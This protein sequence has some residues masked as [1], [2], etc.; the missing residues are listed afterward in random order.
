MKRFWLLFCLIIVAFLVQGQVTNIVDSIG[1]KQGVWREFRVVPFSS[2]TSKIV[3]T[4]PLD[5]STVLFVEDFDFD[6]EFLL[7]ESYG[8]YVD[9]LRSGIWLEYNPVGAYLISKVQYREGIPKGH[10]E[11]FWS[12]GNMK[13]KCFIGDST[14]VEVS[15]FYESGEIFDTRLVPKSEIIKVLYEE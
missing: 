15:S 1:M 9:N 7:I 10:C 6:D 12:N 14:N 8:E 4:N 11:V 13:M 3:I 2:W 5:S